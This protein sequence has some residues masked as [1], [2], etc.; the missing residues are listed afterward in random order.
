LFNSKVPKK[1]WEVPENV[2]KRSDQMALEKGSGI[3]EE[4]VS[5][6]TDSIIAR[7]TGLTV[8]E[9]LWNMEMDK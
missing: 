1:I 3:S 2:M 5:M 4:S 7:F 9:R 8:I 6:T